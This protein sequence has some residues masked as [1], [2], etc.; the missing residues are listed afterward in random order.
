MTNSSLD[1]QMATMTAELIAMREESRES[2]RTMKKEIDQIKA[3]VSAMKLQSAKWKGG[4]AVLAGIG[5]FFLL[6]LTVIE[7]LSEVFRG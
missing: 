1:A 4:I 7:K 6:A 3:D 5:G 2:R